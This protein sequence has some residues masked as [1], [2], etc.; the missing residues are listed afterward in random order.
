M[1]DTNLMYLETRGKYIY[2]FIE[3]EREQK[4]YHQLKGEC[5]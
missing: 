3:R 5:K 1:R 4:V 2:L